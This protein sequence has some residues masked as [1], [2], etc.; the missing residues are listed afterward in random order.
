MTT[1]YDD[2]PI[3]V[4]R[5][6]WG[7]FG[8][9]WWSYVCYDE[10]GQ[11]I[12]EMRKPFPYGE[13]CMHCDEVLDEVAGDGGQAFPCQT[14]EGA[15]IRHAHKE[16]AMRQGVGGLAHLQGRCRCFGGT[17]DESEQDMTARQEAQAVWAW[18]KLHGV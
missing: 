14:T 6:N 12:E 13:R 10:A 1:P 17:D 7:W 11:L 8:P 16:C 5:A 4:R 9:P 18:V 3:E 2:L 15:S